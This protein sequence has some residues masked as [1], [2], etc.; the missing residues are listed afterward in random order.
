MPT[1]TL[2]LTQAQSFVCD[3]AAAGLPAHRPFGALPG[4][5][6]T[7]RGPGGPVHRVQRHKLEPL[8]ARL[9]LPPGARRPSRRNA[10]KCELGL[11]IDPACQPSR[12]PAR[13]RSALF[14]PHLPS[15]CVLSP[16]ASAVSADAPGGSQFP[17]DASTRDTV[18]VG[19]IAWA[20]AIAFI[21]VVGRTFE[22]VRDFEIPEHQARAAS[23]ARPV[24]GYS[25]AWR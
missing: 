2:T 19:C 21:L 22:A 10:Q 8:S 1:L 24:R 15:S 18:I 9:R 14:P 17:D 5:F 16:V 7:L 12:P 23:G 6:G 4:V 20:I 13:L 11:S 25:G 3:S